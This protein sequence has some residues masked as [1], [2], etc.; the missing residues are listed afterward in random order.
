MGKRGKKSESHNSKKKLK[1]KMKSGKTQNSVLKIKS[2]PKM[3]MKQRW[4]QYGV[5]TVNFLHDGVDVI[6]EGLVGETTKSEDLLWYVDEER[7]QE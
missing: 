7:K 2:G 6:D 4:G 3:A 1:K 5:Y